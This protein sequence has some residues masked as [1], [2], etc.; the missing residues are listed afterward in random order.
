[1]SDFTL[2]LEFEHANFGASDMRNEFCNITV[3]LPDGRFYGIN[4]WTFRFLTTAIQLDIAEDKPLAGLYLKPPD[5][6]VKE[7]T[8]ECITATI[9]DLLRTGPLEQALNPSTGPYFPE[10]ES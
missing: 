2:W 1:M 9:A 3:T 8:R 10:E 6:F 5:L 4:V 7:L